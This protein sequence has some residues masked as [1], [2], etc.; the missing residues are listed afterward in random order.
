MSLGSWITSKTTFPRLTL[1]DPVVDIGEKFR[2]VDIGQFSNSNR[3]IN[4]SNVDLA[5]NVHAKSTVLCFNRLEKTT[6]SL[7][8][9]WKFHLARFSRSH[10]D[11]IRDLK[12][13][14][15]P[16]Y[17]P[18]SLGSPNYTESWNCCISRSQMRILTGSSTVTT[19]RRLTTREKPNYFRI[20]LILQPHTQYLQSMQTPVTQPRSTR[21]QNLSTNDTLQLLTNFYTAYAVPFLTRSFESPQLH[22]LSSFFH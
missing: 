15:S 2:T 3:A 12:V 19:F 17:R 18:I 16:V 11:N 6:E 5:I 1:G 9:T 22:S 20:L 10:S 13:S 14:R 4:S 7:P 8:E 21:V